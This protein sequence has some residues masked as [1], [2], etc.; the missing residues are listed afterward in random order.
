[1]ALGVPEQ[2]K[3]LVSQHTHFLLVFP[4]NGGGDVLASALTWR[5]VLLSQGKQVEIVASGFKT[6]KNLHFLTG[7]DKVQGELHGIHKFIIKVDISHAPVESLSYDVKDNWLSI[8]VTPKSGSITKQELRTAQTNFKYDVIFCFGSPDLN[9][10]GDVFFNNTDLFYKTPVINIDCSPR[11]E[12]FGQINWVGIPAAAVSEANYRLLKQMGTD[13]TA[14]LATTILTGMTAATKSFTTPSVTPATLAIASELVEKGAERDTIVQHLYRTRSVGSL[15]LWGLALGHLTQDKPADL[16]ITTL[17]RDDFARTGT[18]SGALSG[19]V[20]ELISNTPEA[21][22][23]V[24]VYEDLS[25]APNTY[26]AILAT[27][28][29]FNAL[30]L[31]AQ[32]NGTGHEHQAQFTLSATNLQ[33]A[34]QKIIEALKK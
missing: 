26:H 30:N 15:K 34:S 19:L 16:V 28:K 12:R 6:P 9:S 14:S 33:E 11:N 27:N 29:N 3:Q 1:M 5:Q 4:A 23:F 25:G 24:L 22:R 18:D 2:I 10:L 21:H 17:T 8:Y 13:I 7:A 31:A 32:F 20:E